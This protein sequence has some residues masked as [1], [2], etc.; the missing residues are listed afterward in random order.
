MAIISSIK[1]Y[2]SNSSFGKCV[3]KDT[4]V[5]NIKEIG[6]KISSAEQRLILGATAIAIQPAIDA[7][8]KS[9]DKQTRK[10]SV[11]RTIAKIVTGTFTGY[12]IRKGCIKA[13]QKWSQI[14]TNNLP[15]YKSMFFPKAT[16]LK[17]D[18]NSDAFK[19]YQNAAGT[20]AALAVMVVSNF[21]IDAPLTKILTNW[22]VD[23]TKNSGGEK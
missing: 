10:V 13:I 5:K 12:F 17:I 16:D 8:N 1:T 22:L 3:R 6:Q 20:I 14:P 18:V 23:K 19:Q 4:Y 15:K 7:N 11:A 2:I 21:A 9:V